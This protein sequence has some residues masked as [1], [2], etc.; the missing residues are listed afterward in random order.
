MTAK[1][2][3]KIIAALRRIDRSAKHAIECINDDGMDQDEAIDELLEAVGDLRANLEALN[4]AIEETAP[5][6]GTGE[7]VEM[8]Q[9]RIRS[10]GGRC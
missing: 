9:G 8:P 4:T 5:S 10:A 2:H 6:D 3:G 1:P 7:A